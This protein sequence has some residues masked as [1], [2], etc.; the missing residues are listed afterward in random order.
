MSRVIDL[1]KAVDY[2]MYKARE[3]AE[4]FPKTY[5]G[6]PSDKDRLYCLF[7]V[8]FDPTNSYSLCVVVCPICGW[9]SKPM[10]HEFDRLEWMSRI[11]RVLGCHLHRKHNWKEHFEVVKY[12]KS[13]DGFRVVGIEQVYICKKCGFRAPNLL[14]SVLHYLTHEKEVE[15]SE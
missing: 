6:M 13:Y 12:P 8:A 9:T 4:I 2:I 1:S 15:S 10:F 3:Y 14:L 11:A 5:T 7:E